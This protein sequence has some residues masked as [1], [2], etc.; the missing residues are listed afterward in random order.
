MQVPLST[1]KRVLVA[2]DN[3]DGA[4]SLA[5]LLECMS[6]EVRAAYNG[7]Q[8]VEEAQVFSPDLVILDID[9]PVL[10]GYQAARQLKTRPTT[11]QPVLVALTA[12]ATPEAVRQAEDAGFDIH[13]QKPIGGSALAELLQRVL[14]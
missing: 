2:D 8:A 4:D 10:N 3:T 1:A 5:L 6:Y 14:H 11:R 13:L 12:I 7:H 9:M